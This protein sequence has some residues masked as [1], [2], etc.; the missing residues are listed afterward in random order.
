[1]VKPGFLTSESMIDE[2]KVSVE[3]W[4]FF[5]T[6]SEKTILIKDSTNIV[7]SMVPFLRR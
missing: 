5:W 6:R 2:I 3:N 7:M 4:R 1:M